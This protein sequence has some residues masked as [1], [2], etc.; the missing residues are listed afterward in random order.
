MAWIRWMV[1]SSKTT[2]P[3][4]KARELSFYAEK[5]AARTGIVISNPRL[6]LPATIKA[7]CH[8]LGRSPR[9]R[10]IDPPNC[11]WAGPLPADVDDCPGAIHP[12]TA[13]RLPV[14]WRSQRQFAALYPSKARTNGVGSA[15]SA[16]APARRNRQS[17]GRGAFWHLLTGS[18]QISTPSSGQLRS[19]S[20][21]EKSQRKWPLGLEKLREGV[22]GPN[23]RRPGV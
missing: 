2:K 10:L 11:V 17:Q 9:A 19:F 1:S 18:G 14:E 22:S 20:S 15:T 13:L 12:R 8:G 6:V 4:P 7:A 16:K 23:G 5:G 3:R 21:T